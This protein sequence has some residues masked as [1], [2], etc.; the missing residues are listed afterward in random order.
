MMTMMMIIII[1][2]IHNPAAVVITANL[3]NKR[4]VGCDLCPKTVPF[5]HLF[6]CRLKGRTNLNC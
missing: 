5:H 4:T 6:N 1:I 2:I 3:A